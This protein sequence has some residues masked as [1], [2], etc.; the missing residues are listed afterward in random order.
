M[1]ELHKN[2]VQAV[3]AVQFY[4]L[5]FINAFLLHDPGTL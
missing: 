1:L 4:P 3:L 5:G 2:M